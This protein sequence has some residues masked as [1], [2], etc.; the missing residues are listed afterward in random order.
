MGLEVDVGNNA[1]RKELKY[2]SLLTD[3]E[4]DYKQVKLVNLSISCLGICGKSSDS[5]LKLYIEEALCRTSVSFDSLY[6][7]SPPFVFR[8]CKTCPKQ[9]SDFLIF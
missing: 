5:F 9:K 6:G 4:N 7:M 2:C 8:E 1:R 3:L